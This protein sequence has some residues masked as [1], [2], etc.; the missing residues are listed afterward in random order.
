M[1]F[2]SRRGLALAVTA[3]IVAATALGAPAD[4][5]RAQPQPT[6][7]SAHYI[8]PPGNYGGLPTTDESRDQLPLCSG[9]RSRVRI[10]KAKRE[11]GWSLRFPTWRRGVPAACAHGPVIS[12]T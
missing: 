10:S 7:D 12:A 6:E 11:L 5:R 9:A 8:L 3:G 2:R 1:S 4:A